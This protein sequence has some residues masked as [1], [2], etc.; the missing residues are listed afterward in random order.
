MNIATLVD[1]Y[2]TWTK[3]NPITFSETPERFIKAMVSD[4]YNFNKLFR[5]RMKQRELKT[6]EYLVTF[7][8]KPTIT[9]SEALIESYIIKQF[10]QKPKQVIEAHISKEY[11]KKGAPHW[12]VAVQT[13]K[14]LKKDRFNYYIQKYG[15][16][17]ISKSRLKSIQESINYINKDSQSFKI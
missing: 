9:D 10:K 8:V 11:T 16:I 17:D 4:N 15:S 2:I 13:T 7:T 12:H 1:E 3:S 14:A 5:Q 6:Y